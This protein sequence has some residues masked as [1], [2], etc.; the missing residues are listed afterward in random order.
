MMKNLVLYGLSANPPT[1]A[2]RTI[3]DYLYDV[4]PK[5]DVW[6]IPV[7]QHPVKTNLIKF[8]H[9][10]NMIKAMCPYAHVSTIEEEVVPLCSYEL[11][12]YIKYYYDNVYDSIIFVCDY[13]IF[14]DTLKLNRLGSRELVENVCF[15]VL[16]NYDT[17]K[18]VYQVDII[19]HLIRKN[20]LSKI[21]KMF[22]LLIELDESIRSTTYRKERSPYLLDKEVYKYILLHRLYDTKEQN[23]QY[24]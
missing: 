20:N 12:S 9:R 15:H 6:I 3:I 17:D 8:S 4:Y 1:I 21:R 2:H 19:D 5:D 18:L 7:Y 13:E 24:V 14:I 10:V 16:L 22:D 23:T 11:V